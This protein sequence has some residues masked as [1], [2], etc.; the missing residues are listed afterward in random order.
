MKV[1][2]LVKNTIPMLVFNRPLFAASKMMASIPASLIN[3]TPVLAFHALPRT[4]SLTR[5]GRFA[6][7]MVSSSR[8]V[9]ELSQSEQASPSQSSNPLHTVMV[10]RNRQSASFRE[11]TPLIFGGSVASTFSE[12]CRGDSHADTIP[13]GSLVAVTVSRDPPPKGV[14][15]KKDARGK[16]RNSD[17]REKHDSAP[18]PHHSFVNTDRE[19]K[20]QD[21][22]NQ[23]QLIGYGV[24]NP[25]SMYRV[26]VLCH[27]TMHPA[28]A[29]EIRSI[30][31]LHQRG[32]AHS[33]ECNSIVL[34][35]ILER[36][37]SDAMCTR[38]AMGL[39]LP[40]VTDTYR[41]INGEGDGLSGL[42][43]DVLGGSTAIV[44]SSAA[45]SEIHK[46]IILAVLEKSLNDHPSYAGTDIG[47]VWRN[48]PSRLKQDG[49]DVV[50][51]SSNDDD[52]SE[53]VSLVATES[54][55]KYLTFPW[56]DGQK[57]GFYCDQRENRLMVAELCRSKRVLDLC[58]YNGGFALNAMIRGSASSA[59]GVDSSQDAVDSAMANAKLNGL[60][61][62]DISFVKD[63]ITAFMKSAIDEKEEFDLIVLDPP[64]L[65]PSIAHVDKASRKYHALNRDAMN[66]INKSEGGLL[67]TCTCSAAMTQKDGGQYFLNMV[68]GAALSAKRRVTL[69][70]VSGAASCHT[71]SPASFPAGAY[72]TAALFHVGPADS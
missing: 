32:S 38:V 4:S 46:D 56:A 27:E 39:P 11:G 60:S 9:E 15:P 67:L 35:L 26:R 65:A 43:V 71:Q 55:V 59:I 31:K 21:V 45:W 36:K 61:E 51:D 16:R 1:T 5:C 14:K 8:N 47:I 37:I 52:K 62:K 13:L 66:L 68:N 40:D 72:L 18:V 6:N 63:D 19:A 69:L 25:E 41:L 17:S 54:G 50:S 29:K 57:T 24:F 48:T 10:H 20:H 44:M 49:Y 12:H 34:Q 64:K 23:S 58:C 7:R 33:E 2:L 70:R 22:I 42:V 53:E 28:L 3:R 30:R